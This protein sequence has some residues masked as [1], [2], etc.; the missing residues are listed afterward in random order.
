MVLNREYFQGSAIF[1]ATACLLAGSGHAASTDYGGAARQLTHAAHGHVLTN[2][3]AWSPDSRWLVYDVRTGGGFTGTRIEKV[4]VE[5]GEVRCLYESGKG[6]ACGVVTWHP[7]EPRVIF[8]HGPEN[9]SSEWTYAVSR[10]RGVIVDA[11][12]SGVARPLDAMNYA[13]PFKAGALRGGSH[14]HVFSPDGQWV[15]FTYD[16]EVLSRLGD[17]GDHDRNQRNV[18][19]AAPLGPVRVDRTHSRN[20]G[21]DYFSVLVTSTVNRPRPGS[22]EIGRAFEEGWIGTDGYLRKDGTRQRR[23]LAFQGLV[24]APDGTEHAEV[25]L[26]DLPDDLTVPGSAPLEGTETRRPAPP[27]GVEQR[28]LTSTADRKFPG[29]AQTPR[30][31]LRSSPDGAQIAF[32]MKDEAGLAQLWLVSPNGGHP[33][34]LTRN[35]WAVDSAFTWSPDGRW[36]AHVMDRSVFLTDTTTGES[37]RLTRRAETAESAPLPHACLVSPDGRWVAFMQEAGPSERGF[38]QVFVVR[39]DSG[40]TLRR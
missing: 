24:T 12:E 40:R 13:P 16:D 26:V 30:H 31:W 37:F 18:G 11:R 29:I 28:R 4:N 3:N 17:Q 10:R 5:T 33:R 7:S 27:A 21:G 8:I 20:H 36:I 23:A 15:S 2:I 9:P 38:S 1:T 34:Q 6:A 35:P 19:V 14:V 39:L 22:D 25:F 32:L